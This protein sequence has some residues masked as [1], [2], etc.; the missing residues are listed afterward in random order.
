MELTVDEWNEKVVLLPTTRPKVNTI[1]TNDDRLL[2]LWKICYLD[3]K[4]ST[5]NKIFINS[6]WASSL[7]IFNVISLS[8][9]DWLWSYAFRR[10]EGRQASLAA[11]FSI[12][13][14]RYLGRLLVWHGRNRLMG[15]TWFV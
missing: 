1:K 7:I 5:N 8:L 15:W 12:T 2:D 4:D 14:F 6:F 9:D 3:K 13:Q 10:Q 11:D